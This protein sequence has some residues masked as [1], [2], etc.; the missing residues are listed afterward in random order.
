MTREVKGTI[1]S[2]KILIFGDSLAGDFNHLISNYIHVES[3]PGATSEQLLEMENKNCGL[4]FLCSEDKYDVVVIF[5]ATNDIGIPELEIFQNLMEL[6]RVVPRSC[7]VILMSIPYSPNLNKILQTQSC[8]LQE[9]KYCEFFEYLSD[10]L[11]R[12]GLH[13]NQE[14]K[15]ICWEMITDELLLPKF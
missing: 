11:T 13:L 5:A 15:E 4:S 3:F 14:G 6:C 10:D 1:G 8:K 9:Y 2:L 12:D 7:I